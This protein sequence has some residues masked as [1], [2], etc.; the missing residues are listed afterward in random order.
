MDLVEV[1]ELKA[2]EDSSRKL[3]RHDPDYALILAICGMI[4]PT[5]ITHGVY[6]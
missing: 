3:K 5:T 1:I 6:R 4:L 2:S